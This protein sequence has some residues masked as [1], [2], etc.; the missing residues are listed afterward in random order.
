MITVKVTY[1]VPPEFV[2]TN[3]ENIERFLEDFKTMDAWAFRYNVFLQQDGVTFVHLSSYE[4]EAVQD[5]VLNVPSF[6]EFQRQR[7]NSGLN[8]THKVEVLEHVGSSFPVF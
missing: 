1:T 8:G 2:E 6:K 4:N 5:A 7:D 3:K